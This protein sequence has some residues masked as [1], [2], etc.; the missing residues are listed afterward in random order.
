[1]NP[2]ELRT[3]V[4]NALQEHEDVASVALINDP[5]LTLGVE[6]SDGRLYTMTIE[7]Q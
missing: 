1:M 4:Y 2:L 3:A 6:S 5:P 7:E